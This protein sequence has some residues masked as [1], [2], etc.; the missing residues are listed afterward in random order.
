MDFRVAVGREHE[1]INI[2]SQHKRRQNEEI[3]YWIY[4][5]L[6]DE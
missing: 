4:D 5:L 1:D 6:L 2:S 3:I